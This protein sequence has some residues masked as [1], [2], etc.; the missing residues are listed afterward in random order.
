[1]ADDE[2]DAGG[3]ATP[4]PSP[5]EA[6]DRTL[7]LLEAT[8][9]FPCDYTLTVIAFNGE[10][11]TEAVKAA[12]AGE[13]RDVEHQI[14]ESKAGKYLSHRFA[15]KATGAAHVLAIYARVRTVDGVVTIL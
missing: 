10:P 1:M 8:H 14:I 2:K 15:V 3:G 12:V 9:A 11:I 6:R 5:D 13:A 4:T 7:A